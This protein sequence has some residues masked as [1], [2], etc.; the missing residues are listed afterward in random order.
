MHLR[1]TPAPVGWMDGYWTLP[2]TE[3]NHPLDQMKKLR[4]G[5]GRDLLRTHRTHWV[6]IW[7]L[8]LLLVFERGREPVGRGQAQNRALTMLVCAWY[9]WRPKLDS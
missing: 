3:F 8:S 4:C 1:N 5:A 2:N 6:H 9:G 7:A